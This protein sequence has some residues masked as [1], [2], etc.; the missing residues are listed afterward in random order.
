[1]PLILAIEPDRRQ[2]HQLNAVVKGRLRA[3]LVLADSAERALK[4]LGDR[5]PDLILTSALLSPTDEMVLGDRLRALNGVAAHVQ[6]LTIPV[7][8]GPKPS[9]RSRAGGMLSALRRGKTQDDATPD[10]CDPSVFAAQCAEYLERAV[11]EQRL[12]AA[13]AVEERTLHI[14]DPVEVA[15]TTPVDATTRAQVETIREVEQ[16]D[17]PVAAAAPVASDEPVVFTK[18]TNPFI[19]DPV[20]SRPAAAKP[21][22]TDPFVAEK[23]TAE[24]V[25]N[26]AFS[27]DAFS[28]ETFSKDTFSQEPIAQPVYSAEPP[29][30]TEPAESPSQSFDTPCESFAPRR[31]EPATPV[32]IDATAA[33]AS[34]SEAIAQIEAYVAREALATETIEKLEASE[35]AETNWETASSGWEPAPR[36]ADEDQIDAAPVPEGFIELDLSTLLEDPLAETPKQADDDEKASLRSSRFETDDEPFVFDI[37]EF[38]EFLIAASKPAVKAKSMFTPEPA[39]EPAIEAG[40]APKPVAKAAPEPVAKIEKNDKVEIETPVVESPAPAG[41][42]KSGPLVA[43]SRLGV[44]QLWPAMDGVVAEAA[45]LNPYKE[46]LAE[47]SARAGANL[48]TGRHKP[49]QDEW[50]FFDPEQCGFAALLAKLD[51]IIDTDDRSA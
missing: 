28:T 32:F 49:I 23:F 31:R 41:A 11:V 38:N 36:G 19:A 6:T 45:A 25:A 26:Q 8:A 35:F 10:G 24:P 40:A 39:S 27:T 43:P 18:S 16:I 48:A 51:E 4:E 21:A 7:L 17:E 20:P 2:A 33:A 14:G 1:M 34:V 50:G 37:N 15:A 44:S 42:R 46:G 30:A 29:A 47:V 3:D 5:V 22:S 13:A 9:A 12:S